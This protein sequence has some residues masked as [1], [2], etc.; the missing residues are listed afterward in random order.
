M[1]QRR[2]SPKL[3]LPSWSDSISRCPERVTG[4]ND[5]LKPAHRHF[6]QV[7]GRLLALQW[8][9]EQQAAFLNVGQAQHDELV[10]P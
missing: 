5:P 4:A 8:E 1:T 10:A 9:R 2:L 6:A 3:H 7:V